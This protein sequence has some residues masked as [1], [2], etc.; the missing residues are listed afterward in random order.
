M[1]LSAFIIFPSNINDFLCDTF[2]EI[3][4]VKTG[5]T[6]SNKLCKSDKTKHKPKYKL[7]FMI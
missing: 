5:F 6:K 3:E 7:I 1:S 2:E 4:E